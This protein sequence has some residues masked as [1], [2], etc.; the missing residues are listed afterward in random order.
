MAV[1]LDP[2]IPIFDGAHDKFISYLKDT[3]P[4]GGFIAR[5]VMLGKEFY[6]GHGFTTDCWHVFIGNEEKIK[7]KIVCMV[8]HGTV[9]PKSRNW[10]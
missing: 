2:S 9:P 10:I 5:T 7:T 3:Y 8:P 4:K 6:N 1:W